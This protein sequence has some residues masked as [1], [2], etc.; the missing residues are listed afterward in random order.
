MNQTVPIL[1]H[2]SKFELED[3]LEVLVFYWYCRLIL[4]FCDIQIS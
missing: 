2:S 3:N 1:K 4:S